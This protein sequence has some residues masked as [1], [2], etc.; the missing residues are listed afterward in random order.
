[1][2]EIE[3]I[4]GGLA[5]ALALNVLHESYKR[6][7]SEAPRVDLVGEEALTKTV[8]S[9]GLKAPKGEKLF[10][11]T[12][13]ADVVSNAMYFS[14]I[15][16]GK[17]KH[18]LLRGAGYGLAAGLGAVFFTKPLG[19]DDTPVTKTNKTKILTVAWYLA[20]GLVTALTIQALKGK[21]SDKKLR[22]LL[23]F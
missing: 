13:A 6:F 21:I 15:G 14:A 2:K 20:G 19:L 4:A 10:G 18:L 11:L 22:S 17:K 16:V 1:M 7:D 12:L 5:G 9:V 23:S 8:E 3:N